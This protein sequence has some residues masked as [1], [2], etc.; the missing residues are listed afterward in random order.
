MFSILNSS[1]FCFKVRFACNTEALSA[2]KM[3]T[4][5]IKYACIRQVP[6][7][8][9]EKKKTERKPEEKK[10]E[11][12]VF[13][14]VRKRVKANRETGGKEKKGKDFPPTLYLSRLQEGQ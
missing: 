9:A 13:G 2:V 10:K 1:I 7:L 11:F 6:I 4:L 8:L 14:D 12:K 3:K 5:L